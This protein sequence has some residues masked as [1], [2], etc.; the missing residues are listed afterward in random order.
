MN[1]NIKQPQEK[2]V[3][4]ILTWKY[5]GEYSFYDNDKTEAKKESII[6]MLKE[7]NRF[8]IYN[9]KDEL[10]GNFSFHTDDGHLLLGVQM[11]PD[12]TGKGM[13]REIV[14]TLLNFGREKLKFNKIELLVAKFNKRA[15]RVYDKLGFKIIDEFIWNVNEEE[16]EFLV[17]EKTY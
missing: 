14:Q 6:N 8:V 5:D 1:I 7:E 12:Y 16:K 17:M 13:G 11:R 9:D 10:I 4:E 3:A 2:D 15:I